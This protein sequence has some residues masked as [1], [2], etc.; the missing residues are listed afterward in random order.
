MR[1]L[2]LALLIANIALFLWGKA[3]AG[4]ETLREASE[5]PV[6]EDNTIKLLREVS[7][8]ESAEAPPASAQ[9]EQAEQTALPVCWALGPF[10]SAEPPFALPAELDTLSWRQESYER[11]IDYWV[12]LGPYSDTQRATDLER[13]LKAANIDSYLIRKGRLEG[14]ISLGVF[15]E[16]LRAER[17]AEAMSKK[18]Y[19]VALRA[20]GEPASQWWLVYQGAP[21][22]ERF[23]KSTAFMDAHKTAPLTLSKKSC[24]LIAS[25]REFD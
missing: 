13:E 25:Y 24:E 9:L 8:P 15:S 12:L 1:V 19:P 3:G 5:A 20:V 16:R 6:V 14:A 7:H 21:N 17:H 22:G 2:L 23:S 10:D 18:G 11:D 4:Y